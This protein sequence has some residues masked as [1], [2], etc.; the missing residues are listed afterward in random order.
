MTQQEFAF[1]EKI[2]PLKKALR[3]IHFSLDAV[4]ET[5]KPFGEL[6]FDELAGA[7]RKRLTSA[8]KTAS[9]ESFRFCDEHKIE[10]LPL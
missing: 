3:Q 1:P 2:K 9:L 10:E 5:R 6:T 4:I 8:K 7:V